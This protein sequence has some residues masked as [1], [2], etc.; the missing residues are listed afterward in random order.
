MVVV[1]LLCRVFVVK[2]YFLAT[3]AIW[4]IAIGGIKHV[5]VAGLAVGK[6]KPHCAADV[7]GKGIDAI[8]FIGHL[9]AI[10]WVP[11][12]EGMI[13]DHIDGCLCRHEGQHKR[14]NGQ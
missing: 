5:P 1:A 3:I 4:A 12:T 6:H 9:D 11:V 2:E 13:T 7:G 14:H 8:P 10:S